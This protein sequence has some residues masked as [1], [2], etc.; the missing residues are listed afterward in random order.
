ME[1][2]ATRVEGSTPSGKMGVMRRVAGL[3]SAGAALVLVLLTGCSSSHHEDTAGP[4]ATTA[5]APSA[6]A[7]STAPVPGGASGSPTSAAGAPTSSAAPTAT[8]GPH[9]TATTAP[10]HA[11]PAKATP[12]GTYTYDSHGSQR[13]G[14]YSSPVSGSATLVISAL[15]NGRQSSSLHNAQGD[16][17]QQLLV[18]DAGSYLSDLQIHAQGLPDKEFAFAKAVLLLPDPARVGATWSWHGTSTD[19]KTNVSASNRVV[20]T[21]TLTIGGRP[22]RT[23]VLQTHLDLSGDINYHA[24]VTTWAA[25]SLRL[26]VKDH[27]VGSG[28]AIGVPFSFDVTDV[29]RSTVPS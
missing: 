3:S 8:A 18:R 7:T 23:V 24:D 1:P 13:T 12:A 21:E 28:T 20:R 29:M 14:A 26:P 5:T 16:T 11:A 2:K 15:R 27:T 10:G 25:P 17:R 6:T 4:G 19:G 9:V 22:V